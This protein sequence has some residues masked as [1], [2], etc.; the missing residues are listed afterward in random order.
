MTQSATLTARGEG[1]GT[2]PN[3]DEVFVELDLVGRAGP[4]ELVEHLAHLPQPTV[5]RRH[6]RLGR[7]V[8]G[9]EHIVHGDLHGTHHGSRDP[10]GLKR[11]PPFYHGT[12][13]LGEALLA[14]EVGTQRRQ[15]IGKHA[16]VALAQR[17]LC[18][19]AGI[20]GIEPSP[21]DSGL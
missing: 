14:Q 17:K 20:D 15:S 12:R 16:A 8:L 2:A 7:V 3:L 21:G 11:G 1:A 5:A 19:H 13:P 9:R 10:G 6:H 18:V 4:L